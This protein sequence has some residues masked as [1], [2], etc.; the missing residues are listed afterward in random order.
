MIFT[1][2]GEKYFVCHAGCKIS[3]REDIRHG[4]I[5]GPYKINGKLVSAATFSMAKPRTCI[6]CGTK[7]VKLT[8]KVLYRRGVEWIA[9]NDE[10]GELDPEVVAGSISCLLL[11]DMFQIDAEKV[12]KAIVVE[13]HNQRRIDT[14]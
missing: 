12:A 11:A 6:Y 10:P 4:V 5:Y 1:L 3:F 7:E 13:R 8:K 14:D 2:R 9:H